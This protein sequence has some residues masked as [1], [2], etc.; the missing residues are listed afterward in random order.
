MLQQ[1][2][3]SKGI[4]EEVGNK[5]LQ[6]EIAV[7]RTIQKECLKKLYTIHILKFI[8]TPGCITANNIPPCSL[9]SVSISW[10][11]IELPLRT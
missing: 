8:E 6:K 2:Q 10:E 5:I 3:E 11:E 4:R 1:Q 7:E 9:Q